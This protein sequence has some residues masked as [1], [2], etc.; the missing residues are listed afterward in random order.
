MQ[1]LTTGVTAA[2]L[3]I[4]Q[5]WLKLNNHIASQDE[6]QYS[7]A[8]SSPQTESLTQTSLWHRRASLRLWM[9]VS[10]RLRKFAEEGGGSEGRRHP[11]LVQ[12]LELRGWRQERAEQKR[13]GV[14]SGWQR[15][16]PCTH[17]NGGRHWL[18]SGDGRTL[19]PSGN[20]PM[21]GWK[22]GE[23]ES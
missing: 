1:W 20:K 9:E 23:T 4:I 13:G 15:R 7:T 12:C 14:T 17:T 19:V 21:C 2:S 22:G 18:F 3:I 5:I 10:S 8:V 6:V 11:S 16:D